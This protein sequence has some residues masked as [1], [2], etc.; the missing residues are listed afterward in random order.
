MFSSSRYLWIVLAVGVAQV[1]GCG[2]TIRLAGGGN[3]NST[4]VTFTFT[5]ATPTAAATEVG[6]GSFTAVTAVSNTVT[7]SVPEGTTDF[8]VAYLCPSYTLSGSTFEREYVF[9][10][11]L[12]DGNA[13]EQS[14]AAP[15]SAPSQTGTLSGTVDATAISGVNMVWLEGGTSSSWEGTGISG[16][17]A[18]VSAQLPVGSDEVAAVA[19]QNTYSGDSVA[20]T[21]VA[22]KDLG[23][24][25]VPG[26]ANNGS[27]IVLTGA[28]A[29]TPQPV[30][31]QNVPSS[32]A[33][34]TSVIFMTEEG[35]L[36]ALQSSTNSSYPA[37]PAAML[38]GGAY[39]TALSLAGDVE[40]SWVSFNQV[41]NTGGGPLTVVFPSPWSYS[42]P[43]AAALPVFD[44]SGYSGFSE[45]A[46]VARVG[47]EHWEPEAGF[48]DSYQVTASASFQD[49]VGTLVM[50]DLSSLSG[51]LAVPP[52][53]ATVSW[54]ALIS[55]NN[56]GAV[57]ATP[58][59][60]ST[61]TVQNAGNFAVP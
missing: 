23:E 54:E 58:M 50:P 21:V 12:E 6:S 38:Q 34:G 32:A 48:A 17:V 19:S 9:E 20:I 37:V 51:F 59:N 61:E 18:D 49:G 25:M 57:G 15:L 33:P 26:A 7:L 42:G 30:T 60:S 2:G 5:G 10:A 13:F 41:W 3:G 36:I 39:Y 16:N 43:A 8:A 1:A 11:T 28:D 27:P 14:C 22:V 44:F 53:G 52:S 47:V 4:T 56:A 46:G 55:Q 31:Y 24:Q 40:T 29:T 45:T 35:G